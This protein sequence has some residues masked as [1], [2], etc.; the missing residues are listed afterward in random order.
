MKKL[1]LITILLLSLQLILPAALQ[2]RTVTVTGSTELFAAVEASKTIPITKILVNADTLQFFQ[3]LNLPHQLKVKT[4]FSRLIIDF[5]GAEIYAMR[6]MP[7]VIGRAIPDSMRLSDTI[8]KGPQWVAD[9]IMQSQAFTIQNVF[10]D[11]M[12]NAQEGIVLRSTFHDFIAWC[13][14]VGAQKDGISERFGMNAY[15]FQCEVRSCGG[16]GISLR[17][18]DYPGAAMNNSGSNMAQVVASRVFPKQGQ[19]SS[20]ASIASGNTLFDGCISDFASG[21]IPLREFYLDNT[22]STTC[23]NITVDRFWLESEVAI[24]GAHIDILGNGGTIDLIRGYPQKGGTMIRGLGGNYTQINVEK[25]GNFLGK[26]QATTNNGTVWR[27]TNNGGSYDYAKATNW[28]NTKLP[29]SFYVERFG[30]DQAWQ[31]YGPSNRSLKWNES[32]LIVSTTLTNILKG[33]Q[34]IAP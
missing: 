9:N 34:K 21:Q 27:F 18:G 17:P 31:F 7:Y 3:P 15:I 12:G 10:I 16:Y 29:I 19:L 24:T 14:V 11:C 25:W 6:P 5:Q 2:A 30:S 32:T 26:N 13:T 33:Y 1:F 23:K 28:V 22:G 4:R 8:V 20:F